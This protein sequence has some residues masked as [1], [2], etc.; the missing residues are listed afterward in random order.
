[1]AKGKGRNSNK[2]ASNLQYSLRSK[3]IPLQNQDHLD[4]DLHSEG[5]LDEDLVHSGSNGV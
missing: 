2:N 5:H 3:T 4:V 1:M